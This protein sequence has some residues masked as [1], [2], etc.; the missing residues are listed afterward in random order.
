MFWTLEK[1]ARAEGVIIGENNFISSRFWSSEPYL[2]KVGNNCQITDD[3]TFFTHGGA[4][5]ARKKYPDFDTFGKV[6]VGDYVYIGSGSKL[7]PGV[8][9]GDNVLIAAGSIV[10]KSIPSNV[11][12]AGN[13]AK[14]ICSIDEYICRNMKYNTNTKN[15]SKKNKD[16]FLKTMPVEKFI[17]KDFLK[18]D[19][20]E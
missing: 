10:T 9:I 14:Y 8:T 19:I 12:V 2:I 16:M 20:H 1:Q 18:I 4:G 15:I 11:V 5:A 3:V 13:P 6:V 7:M 17:K